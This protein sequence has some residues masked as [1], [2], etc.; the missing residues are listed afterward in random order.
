MAGDRSAP[1]LDVAAQTVSWR[2]RP[3]RERRPSLSSAQPQGA[4]LLEDDHVG[5]EL[6]EPGRFA[7]VAHWDPLSRVS[8]S[9][10]VLLRALGGAGYRTILVSAAPDSGLLDW[11]DDR[12][13][14]VTVMRRP[15][16]GYD[17]GSWATALERLPVI[18]RAEMVLLFND[19]MAGPFAPMDALLDHFRRSQADVWAMTDT[20][21]LG[22]HLQS[23]CLGFKGGVLDDPSL[24]RFWSGIGVEQTREAVIERYE[25]GLSRLL[26]RRR[27]LVDVAIPSWKV[28]DDD[29]NPTIV[30]W[31]RLLDLG[32][33]F[34]KRQVL[35]EPDVCPDG[36]DVRDELRRRF[37]VD[38]DEWL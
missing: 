26:A 16:V 36:G 34:V 4:V 6:T 38:A 9:V 14:G 12:P 37:D 8:R 5:R 23:Y 18:R 35:R 7:V 17:F 2:C 10:R 33:P 30:G 27:L 24:R 1:Q 32:F 15:N 28:V 13:A 29:D 22:H 25:L 20:R 21:Q 19:S 31:R 3:R 11:V